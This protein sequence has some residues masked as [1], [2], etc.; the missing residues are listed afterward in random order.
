MQ[1][2]LVLIFV[3]LLWGINPTAMKVGLIYVEPMPYNAIRMILA[4]G[5]GI[6]VAMNIIKFKN[7][8]KFGYKDIFIASLGF[9]L[10]QIF[11]TTGVQ[12]T[13]V[14]NASLILSCLPISVAL[15]N[16]LHKL[17][18]VSVNLW[19]SILFS[20]TGVII[21]ILSTGKNF[22]LAQNHLIGGMMLFVAQ[23]CYGYYTVFSKQALKEYS[24][25]QVT[26][27]IL[28]ISTILFIPFSAREFYLTNWYNVPWQGW[29]S[30]FYSGVFPLCLGNILWIWGAGIIGSTKASVYNNLPPVFSVILGCLVFGENFGIINVIGIGFIVL[31]L[32]LAKK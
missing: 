16:Y 10:F 18:K 25:Y 32:F 30:I 29:M 21:M 12:L 8:I 31:G 17:E 4:C 28:I 2:P 20:I 6:L 7:I 1:V 5:V 22:S 23:F 27:Y 26:V 9:F 3:A 15:I 11:F 19:W 24:A 13:T 14:G